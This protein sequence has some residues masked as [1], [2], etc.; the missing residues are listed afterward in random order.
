MRQMDYARNKNMAYDVNPSWINVPDK[1]IMEWYNKF[2]HGFIC[3]GWKPY[4]FENEHHTIFCGITS[5]LCMPQV[6][7]GNDRLAQLGPKMHSELERNVWLLI[8][9][10]KPLFYTGKCEVM[11]SFFL[12]QMVLFHLHKRGCMPSLS[13]IS[14][15]IDQRLFQGISLTEIFQTR[16]W[17]V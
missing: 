6:V 12:F 9:K 5:V 17:G 8:R 14:T 16:R 4:P 15:G 10:C 3:F 13:S 1:I 2:T 11:D 7:E